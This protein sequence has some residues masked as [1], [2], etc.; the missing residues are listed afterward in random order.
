MHGFLRLLDATS[1]EWICV[2][3]VDEGSFIRQR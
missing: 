2:E 1:P 3:N